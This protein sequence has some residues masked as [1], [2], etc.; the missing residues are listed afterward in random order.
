MTYADIRKIASDK[1]D[2]LI[3]ECGVFFA[4]SNEQFEQGK[5]PL[6]DGD[7]YVSI[8]AGGYMPKSKVDIFIRGMRDIAKEERKEIKKAKNAQ[9]EHIAYELNNHECYYTGSIE[10]AMA[11]LPYDRKEV[12]KV[13]IAER[14]KQNEEVTL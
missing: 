8:G 3:R 10:D 9:Y 5:T 4:F 11:V 2:T 1:R 13:F 7:K 12:M 14:A 6:Q